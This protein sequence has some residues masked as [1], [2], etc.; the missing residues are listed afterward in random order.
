MPS[1]K[2]NLQL[3]NEIATQET[4]ISGFKEGIQL[5]EK[6]VA[7]NQFLSLSNR[8]FKNT[9]KIPQERKKML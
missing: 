3:K 4:N 5:N 8:F 7:S 9:V 2:R 6:K 1:E